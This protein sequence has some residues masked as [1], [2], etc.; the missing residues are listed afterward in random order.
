M[1]YDEAETDSPAFDILSSRWAQGVL[2]GAL[3]LIPARSYPRW[4]RLSIIW[5]PTAIAASGGAYFAGNPEQVQ[6][7]TKQAAGAEPLREPEPTAQPEHTAEPEFAAQPES[8]GRWRSAAV[9]LLPAAAVGTVASGAM[10]AAAG[11]ATWW[12]VT[13][14]NERERAQQG[15]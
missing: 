8:V 13:K 15:Q 4:L 7:L 3:T 9:V 6:K 5:A 11:A 14:E 1:G 2:T 10:A 12:M